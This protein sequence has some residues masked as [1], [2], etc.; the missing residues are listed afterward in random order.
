MT[1]HTATRIGTSRVLVLLDPRTDSA[2]QDTRL[3][4]D[5]PLPRRGWVMRHD[6][7]L[8]VV[9][10]FVLSWMFWPLVLVN[11]DSSPLVPFGPLLSAVMVAALA[12]RRRRV[13]GLLRQLAHWRVHPI[14][15]AIA[16]GAP[17][18]LMGLAVAVTVAIGAPAPSIGAVDWAALPVTLLSTMV[19]IGLF[20]EV[21]WRGFALPTLQRTH[22]ALWSALVIGGVW[23][24]W[25]LPE[26]I[27]DPAGQ[28]AALPFFR[29]SSANR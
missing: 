24:A 25:H 3:P 8:F 13:A 6:L 26:L 22:G 14:W 23:A 17:L 21:G 2:G 15:Y 12:G 11:P 7:A 16:L 19:I 29:S 1:D 28:P 5:E 10:T 18:V 20:E 27:S 4:I 9:S